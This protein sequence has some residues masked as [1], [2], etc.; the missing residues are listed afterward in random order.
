MPQY[1]LHL[2]YLPNRKTQK[3]SDCMLHFMT[4]DIF[5]SPA[6]TLVNPVNCVGVMGAGLALEFKKRFP[7]EFKNYVQ[8]CRSVGH[9]CGN[10]QFVRVRFERSAPSKDRDYVLAGTLLPALG[11]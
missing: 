11:Y 8:F 5:D 9:A 7:Q 3:G 4:G 6:H 2:Q 10:V 1:R